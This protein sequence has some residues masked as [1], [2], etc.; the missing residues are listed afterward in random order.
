MSISATTLTAQ[1]PGLGGCSGDIGLDLFGCGK[2][3][4]LIYLD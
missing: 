1:L 3:W 4:P 2:T